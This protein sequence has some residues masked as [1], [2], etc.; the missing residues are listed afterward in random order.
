MDENEIKTA[1]AQLFDRKTLSQIS[2]EIADLAARREPAALLPMTP[3]LA[4][5]RSGRGTG[6]DSF[7]DLARE[8]AGQ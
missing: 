3:A 8:A 5:L 4:R 7:R 1:L 6:F 2:A